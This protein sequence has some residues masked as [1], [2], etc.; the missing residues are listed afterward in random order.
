MKELI[1]I[2]MIV[3]ALPLMW[4]CTKASDEA[5]TPPPDVPKDTAQVDGGTA[6]FT[7]SP[8]PHWMVDMQDRQPQPQYTAPDP[9]AYEH[10]MYVMVRLQEE[11]VPFSTD[12]DVMA[13]F[14]G[15]ECRALSTRDGNQQKV[16]F[17]LNVHGNTTDRSEDFRLYYY[18]GGLKQLFILNAPENTFFNERTVGIE[19]DFSPSFTWG[20]TK[21]PVRIPVTVKVPE[22]DASSHPL[23]DDDC[24]AVFVGDECRGVGKMGELFIVFGYE[25][26]EQA[27]LRYYSRLKGG[28]YTMAKTLTLSDIPQTLDFEF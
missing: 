15:D 24:V 4:C 16:F 22:T 12:D 26:D 1:R 7:Q 5:Q 9:S 21:F 20:S 14:V 19:S 8:A 13:V 11:L 10:V 28:F 27:Q 25:A 23:A 2:I 6:S 18:S 3:A 17:I